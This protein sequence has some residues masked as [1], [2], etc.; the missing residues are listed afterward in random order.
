[1]DLSLE[2][3]WQ[4]KRVAASIKGQVNNLLDN[5]YMTVLSRPMAGRNYAVYL[6][7]TPQWK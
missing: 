3:K 5:H 6:S 7:V 2:K 1:M 4:W